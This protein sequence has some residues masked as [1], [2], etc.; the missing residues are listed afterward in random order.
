MDICWTCKNFDCPDRSHTGIWSHCKNWNKTLKED[1]CRKCVFDGAQCSLDSPGTLIQCDCFKYKKIDEMKQVWRSWQ[2]YVDKI[3]KL[4]A[5]FVAK[6][7]C[8]PTT[9]ILN[10]MFRP[11][12]VNV[13]LICGMNIVFSPKISDMEVF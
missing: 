8:E 2:I 5:D 10:D 11:S 1:L 6:Y 7:G 13:S 12:F 9:I 3:F 4:K